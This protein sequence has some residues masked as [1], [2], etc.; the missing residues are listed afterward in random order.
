MRPCARYGP[1]RQMFVCTT[2]EQAATLDA[3]G[4]LDLPADYRPD[5][6]VWVRDWADV[7]F[8]EKREVLTLK[9]AR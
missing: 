1:R 8:E 9:K 3:A 4:W 7:K 5:E 6:A 2:E